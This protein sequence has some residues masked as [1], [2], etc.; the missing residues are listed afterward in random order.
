MGGPAAVASQGPVLRS[1]R[2]ADGARRVSIAGGGGIGKR[3]SVS[4]RA[5]VLRLLEQEAAAANPIIKKG[6]R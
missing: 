6:S 3:A 4:R 2:L 1:R 5:G